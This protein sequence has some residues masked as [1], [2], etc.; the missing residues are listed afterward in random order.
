MLQARDWLSFLIGIILGALGLLPFLHS[1]GK[2]PGWFAFSWLP[3]G[4]LSYLIAA[5]GFYLIINSFIEIT[6]SNIVGWISFG[7]AALIT[8]TGI[9]KILG[10]KEIV[11]G[12]LAIGW[13]SP[14]FYHFIFMILG[15]FL[16]IATFAMEL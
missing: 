8:A 12:L 10:Q 16:I 9:L 11:S 2:G 3:L 14:M 6:N 4:I 7:I 15:L 13:L 5:G 1:I